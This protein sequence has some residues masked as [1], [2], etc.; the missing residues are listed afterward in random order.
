M[1]KAV[2]QHLPPRGGAAGAVVP[3][4]AVPHR[5]RE[6]LG[7]LFQFLAHTAEGAAVVVVEG[8]VIA[9]V[10]VRAVAAAAIPSRAVAV[11]QTVVH[12][13]VAFVGVIAAVGGV[14]IL[15]IINTV[16]T[17]IHTRVTEIGMQRA[18]G[19]SAGSLYK[20]FL[21]EGA[22]YGIIASVIGS[23]LGYVCTI[24]IEAATSDTL[25]LVAIPVIPILEATLLAVGACLMAT[26]IPLRKISKMSIVDSIETVE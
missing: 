3:R 2:V 8:V 12:D 20:T 10:A 11:G 13:A 9:P 26:A 7:I 24:F 14:V 5:G 25:Q 18:I 17:N 6:L 22:Y 19:M 4:H 1:D 16:Y 23:V 21:W 15:N